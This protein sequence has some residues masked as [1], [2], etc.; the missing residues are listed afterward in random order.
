MFC[1]KCGK[2]LQGVDQKF[3][4]NCGT[5]V[6]ATSIATGFKTE[7]TQYVSAPQTQYAPVRPQ[8]EIRIGPPGKYSKM[9]L[10]LAIVSIGVGLISLIIGYNI[11]RIYY[12][13]YYNPGAR[14]VIPVVMLVLRGGGLTM[15]IL[16]KGNGSKAVML[17]P[18]NSLEKVGSILGIFGIITNS[19]GLF[20][21]SVYLIPYLF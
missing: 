9:C 8:K 6:I 21:S 12:W 15:G 1:A 20:L 2:E 4:P 10:V 7:G 5:E 18:Y 16:S 13:S 19:I 3:C 14:V 11:S 17:E